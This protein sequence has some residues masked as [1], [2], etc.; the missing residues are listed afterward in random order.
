MRLWRI[1]KERVGAYS[2]RDSVGVKSFLFI[3]CSPVATSRIF[4]AATR[5]TAALLINNSEAKRT[6]K[7]TK[8]IT[9][10]AL[11][12]RPT[13]MYVILHFCCRS[14]QTHPVTESEG[15]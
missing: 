7:I 8:S 2:E 1:E 3:T 9:Y 13:Y 5:T 6:S 11:T 4:S 10:D 14:E 15:V 12:V